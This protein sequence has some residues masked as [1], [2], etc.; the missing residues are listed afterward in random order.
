MKRKIFTTYFLVF[1]FILQSQ[2]TDTLYFKDNL[3]YKVQIGNYYNITNEKGKILIKLN[4]IQNIEIAS[5][6]LF[7]EY[8]YLK[9]VNNNKSGLVDLKGKLIIPF[10]YDDIDF[11]H[12]KKYNQ[13]IMA[14]KDNYWGIID[15]KNNEIIPFTYSLIYG[16]DNEKL[17][18]YVSEENFI[19]KLK[20]PKNDFIYFGKQVWVSYL[21]NDNAKF[22]E[23]GTFY[24]SDIT[25]ELKYNEKTKNTADS[26]NHPIILNRV[27]SDTIGIVKLGIKLGLYDLKNK[28]EIATTDYDF[29]L[30]DSNISRNWIGLLTQTKEV[31]YNIKNKTFTKPYESIKTVNASNNLVAYHND[32]YILIDENCNEISDWFDEILKAK[33]Y[34]RY[35]VVKRGEKY[36]TILFDGKIEIPIEY[37][38]PYDWEN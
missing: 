8:G 34:G 7:D 16:I 1:T 37:L 36:G 9:V 4:Q 18:S 13:R 17:I 20:T 30:Y 25:K 33:N 28:K 15:F 5:E 2:V 35:L 22:E 21:M 23:V 26:A 6:K 24:G 32:K 27:I 3:Y 14:K 11:Y 38:K 29:V 19:E 10:Q 12:D 31:Y